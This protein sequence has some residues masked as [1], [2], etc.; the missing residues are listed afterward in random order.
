MRTTRLSIALLA[1]LVAAGCSWVPRSVEI[2]DVFVLPDG[3]TLEMYVASCNA[4][5]NIE[6]QE[7]GESVAVWV[8]AV[9]DS[10][11]DCADAVT[12]ELRAELGDRVFVDGHDLGV[13]EVQE[14]AG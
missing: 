11:D 4:E 1:A 9:N 8:T 13:L 12:I 3:R 5:H 14:R 10:N 7:D 6:V 2:L